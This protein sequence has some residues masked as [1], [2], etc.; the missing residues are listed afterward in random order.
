MFIDSHAHIEGERFDADR[1]QVI[2]RARAAGVEAIVEICNGDLERGSLEQGLELAAAHDF[3]YAVVGMHPHDAKLWDAEWERRLRMA[4]SSTRVIAWGEIGLDYHYN[5][6]KPAT[7]RDVFARQLDIAAELDLPVV[8]HTREADDD[9][10]SIL[11][12]HLPPRRGI[13]HCFSSDLAMAIAALQFG[14]LLSFAGNLT[15][16][17]AEGLREVVRSLP[18]D[19]LL[20]ETD[21]PFLTPV[22]FRGQ[23]NEPMHVKEVA[24]QLGE[25]LE[26]TT[27]E[28]GQ[29]TS[30]NFRRFYGLD[31][32]ERRA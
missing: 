2:T 27:E 5:H 4:A 20:I 1:D 11:A 30:Q 19:R 12:Q 28:A 18:R 10:L 7:Q 13:F 16:R 24:R 32:A 17:N 14:F 25:L 15:F 22:P 3:I 29:L 23:R 31:G 8:I 26:M 9:T 6:S 21:S